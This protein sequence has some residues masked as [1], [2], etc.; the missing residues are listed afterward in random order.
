MSSADLRTC[1]IERTS[2][3]ITLSHND[4]R[5]HAGNCGHPEGAP[6]DRPD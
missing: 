6:P 1:E 2:K 5:V 4:A 3:L